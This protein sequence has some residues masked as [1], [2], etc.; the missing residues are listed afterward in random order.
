MTE[1][2]TTYETQAHI[3]GKDYVMFAEIAVRHDGI[4]FPGETVI[5][6]EE[7]EFTDISGEIVIQPEVR[8]ELKNLLALAIERDGDNIQM[9]AT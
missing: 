7:Y 8:R 3:N 6:A 2:F 1:A 5:E 4:L 9:R